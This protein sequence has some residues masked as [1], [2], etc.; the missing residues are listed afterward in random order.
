MAV[1]DGVE[2]GGGDDADY[3]VVGAELERKRWLM[4]ALIPRFFP[5]LS[6]PSRFP[7]RFTNMKKIFHR[8][9]CNIRLR[10]VNYGLFA[11]GHPQ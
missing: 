5:G 8:F 1:R 4:E 9:T 11:I 10:V 2:A 7:R 6:A 3:G